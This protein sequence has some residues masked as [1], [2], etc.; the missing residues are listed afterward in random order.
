MNCRH[1][2]IISLLVT[3][4]TFAG[5]P[6]IDSTTL[7]GSFESGTVS[8]WSGDIRAERDDGFPSHGN[9]FGIVRNGP[10]TPLGMTRG[11]GYQFFGA[12][13]A[14]GRT[15]V[16]TF[17]ARDAINGFDSL[18]VDFFA[19]RIDGTIVGATEVPLVFP[20]LSSSAWQT[21][22][23]QYQLPETWTGDG[24]VSLQF[25]FSREGAVSGSTYVGYLD[26]IRFEQVPEPSF[27]ALI[28]IAGLLVVGRR[29]CR[30]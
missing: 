21:Y 22:Q 15:F 11:S 30:Q 18:S 4:R 3:F 1:L 7:N 6:L 16:A 20:P 5:T 12:N 17:D 23:V 2:L 25:L 26:N 19:T 27:Y 28:S 9:W 8:P 10:I 29:L 13:P 14:A 24:Q